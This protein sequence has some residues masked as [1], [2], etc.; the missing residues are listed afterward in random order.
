LDPTQDL[1]VATTLQGDIGCSL[2]F[3]PEEG[4]DIVTYTGALGI[5]PVARSSGNY[6]GM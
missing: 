6:A 1:P 5:E 3:E 2:G 4:V